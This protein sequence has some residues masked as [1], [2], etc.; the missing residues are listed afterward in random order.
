MAAKRSDFDE[1]SYN[2]TGLVTKVKDGDS[3]VVVLD[4][5]IKHKWEDVE[6]RLARYNS[7]ET[8]DAP[9]EE[10]ARGRA[11]TAFFKSLVKVGDYVRLKTVKDRSEKYKRL[12]AEVW[13]D[14]KG[15]SINQQMLNAGYG[16]PYDGRGPKPT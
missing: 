11:A 13:V 2:Y 7:P 9:E 1:F 16:K 5:G 6:V 14:P 8:H 3:L 12:L 10:L 4:F 15:L